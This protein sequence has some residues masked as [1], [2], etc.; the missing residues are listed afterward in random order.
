[1]SD[2]FVFRFLVKLI[3]FS[4]YCSKDGVLNTLQALVG[5]I[6]NRFSGLSNELQRTKRE[7]KAQVVGELGEIN[8]EM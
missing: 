4:N 3:R 2:I 7:L 5:N 1:M 8:R 6:Q